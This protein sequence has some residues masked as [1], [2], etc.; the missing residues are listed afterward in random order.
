MLL[1]TSGLLAAFDGNDPGH[2]RALHAL[3]TATGR[4]L[5]P[6]LVL[7]E[8]DYL[9]TAKRGHRIRRL[10]LGALADGPYVLASFTGEDLRRAR[11]IDDQYSGLRLGVV[12]ASILALAE[13]LND[14]EILTFDERDFRSIRTDRA[15]RLLPAD[16]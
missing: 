1:D 9:L 7:A 12:D 13:R 2:D 3:Q 11:Q 8:L 5:L 4:L 16:L 6:P 10:A 15:L 14:R